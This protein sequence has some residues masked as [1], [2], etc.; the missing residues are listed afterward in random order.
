MPD[1]RLTMAIVYMLDQQGGFTCG[2]TATGNTNYAYP[3]SPHAEAAKRHPDLIAN[4][5][6]REANDVGHWMKDEYQARNW[7]RLEC[8]HKAT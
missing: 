5:M 1:E 4:R 7:A 3:S 2:D 6:V 8:Q